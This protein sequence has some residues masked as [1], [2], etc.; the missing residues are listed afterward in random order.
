[1]A[2]VS[3]NATD[4][5]RPFQRLIEIL[6]PRYG[7]IGRDKKPVRSAWGSLRVDNGSDGGVVVRSEE[8]TIFDNGRNMTKAVHLPLTEE[9]A[10]L[11]YA[12]LDHR[13]GDRAATHTEA[14]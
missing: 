14:S 5:S 6:I 13:Y 8:R 10:R 11:L 7:K 4:R 3:V 1:M 12:A 2:E 9:Q